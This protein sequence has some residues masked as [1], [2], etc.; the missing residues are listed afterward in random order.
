MYGPTIFHLSHLFNLFCRERAPNSTWK[1]AAGITLS[2]YCVIS[3]MRHVLVWRHGSDGHGGL[4]IENMEKWTECVCVK[5]E[6]WWDGKEVNN[7]LHLQLH[8]IYTNDNVQPSEPSS[9]LVPFP[10]YEQ[11]M[12]SPSQPLLSFQ[13]DVS[14]TGWEHSAANPESH[15]CACVGS[16]SVYMILSLTFSTCFVLSGKCFVNGMKQSFTLSGTPYIYTNGR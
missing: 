12:L 10:V 13:W 6:T 2:P 16:P 1:M 3:V 11:H 15:V 4:C 14:L 9:V 8:C 7:E 5:M